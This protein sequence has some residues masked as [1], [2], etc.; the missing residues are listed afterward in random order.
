LL[1][2]TPNGAICGTEGTAGEDGDEDEEPDFVV[3]KPTYFEVV[4]LITVHTINASSAAI[5]GIGSYPM[6]SRTPRQDMRIS[7]SAKMK[8]AHR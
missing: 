5:N 7:P 1:L 8:I 4:P 2:S 3:A 6:K